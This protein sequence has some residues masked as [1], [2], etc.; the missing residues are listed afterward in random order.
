MSR[1]PMAILTW[2]GK[3]PIDEQILLSSTIQFQTL[4]MLP[5][6]SAE[7]TSS[8]LLTPT[9]NW[10]NRLICGNKSTFLPALLPEFASAIDLIYI[11]PPFMTG[12]DFTI[13]SKLAYSDKWQNDL[14]G[15]LQWLYETFHLLHL[16]LSQRG[17]LYV[18]LD[19]RTTHYAK[20]I[21][22]EI[23]GFNPNTEG[24]GFKSEIIW[25]YQT[26]G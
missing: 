4:E 5:A 17:S 21:L 15:Y 20:L 16:L 25:H 24:A 13:N 18:H 6:P 3:H 26:G 22:D 10:H 9:H 8:V 12:R 2:K 19:W 14:D 1:Y 11:D 7:N 23:F